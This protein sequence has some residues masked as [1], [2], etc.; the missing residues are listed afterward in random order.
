MATG[1]FD[2]QID[3]EVITKESRCRISVPEGYKFGYAIFV[4]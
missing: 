2:D 1:L 4:D 3:Q